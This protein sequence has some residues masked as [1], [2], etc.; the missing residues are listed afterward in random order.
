LQNGHWNS[1]NSTIVTHASA[2]PLAG[3][4]PTGTLNVVLAG[5]AG[6]AGAFWPGLPCACATWR[7]AS[8][9]DFTVRM[10]PR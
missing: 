1:E 4:V 2:G 6:F 9:V 7:V 8:P 5:S 10:L 3:E